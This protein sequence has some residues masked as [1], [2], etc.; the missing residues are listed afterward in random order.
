MKLICVVPDGMTDFPLKAL[1][2][3]TPLQKAN[4]PCMDYLLK[5]G[6]TGIVHTVPRGFKPGSDTANLSIMG[7]DPRTIKIGRGALEALARNIRIKKG[8]HIFR[9]NF[10]TIEDN[11][12][13]DYTGGNIRT[14]DSKKL[15]AFLNKRTDRKVRFISGVDYRNLAVIRNDQIQISTV[16]P[17]DILNKKIDDY[18]PKGRS[19]ELIRRIMF[20]TKKWLSDHPVNK[21]KKIAAN[22]VWLWGEGDVDSDIPSFFKRFGLKG[23]VI[24][25]VDI[26]RGIA[27]L[28]KMDVIKVPGITGYFDTNYRNKAIYALRNLKKYDYIFLHIEA[29]D[30]AGHHG[31]LGEKIRAI[32]NVDRLVIKT[33][34]EAK[35]NF[36]ILILPDHPTP[37]TLRKHD[38]GPVPFILYSKKKSLCPNHT[39][40]KYDES[41]LENPA[42]RIKDG[43]TLLN[44][45]LKTLDGK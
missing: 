11:V 26:I 45:V 17:H 10:V 22:M 29:T 39:F 21:N 33:L 13:K 3:K 31:D 42:V 36:D 24:T 34:L 1:G 30:E 4:T 12:M 44:W 18:L 5:N 20:D 43:F 16:P 14:R 38:S 28:L 32:E 27:R 19:Q 7:V 2:N 8:E 41:T 25:A 9:A 6:M 37:I 35:D 40:M 15:I 23:A